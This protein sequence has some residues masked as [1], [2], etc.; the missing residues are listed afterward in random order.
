MKIHVMQ[1]EKILENLSHL[2]NDIETIEFGKLI[3]ITFETLI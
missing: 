2:A 3:I 1:I